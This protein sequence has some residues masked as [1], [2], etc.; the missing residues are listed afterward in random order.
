[1]FCNNEAI[2]CLIW[3]S[4]VVLATIITVGMA[5]VILAAILAGLFI[6]YGVGLY[7]HDLVVWV[8]RK[9]RRART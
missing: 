7:L 6:L 4:N 1:M 3:Q 5:V 8:G 2:E 9:V